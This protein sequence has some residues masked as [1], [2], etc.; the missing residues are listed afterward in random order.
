M[1]R[2]LSEGP[3]A[4]RATLATVE[5]LRASLR[6]CLA[7]ADRV[8]LVGT[9]ASLAVIATAAPLWRRRLAA[10]SRVTA[11]APDI[12]VRQS[13]EAV[14]GA[15]GI[16]WRRSDLA[17]LVSQSGA[18]PESVRAARDTRAA[19]A[20]VVAVTGHPEASLG[21]VADLIVPLA[22]GIETDASTKAALAS[23]AALLAVGEVIPADAAAAEAIACLLE[24]DA[25]EPVDADLI[26]RLADARHVWF[27]GSGASWGLATAG[28]LLW[29][30]KV[31]RPAGAATPSEFRHG[32]VE[33]VRPDDAVMLVDVDPPD[34]ARA[35]YLDRLRRELAA[36]AVPL[37]E[38]GDPGEGPEEPPRSSTDPLGWAGIRALGTLLRLQRIA[39]ATA[40][41]AG[42][43]RDGFAVLRRVVTP[44]TELVD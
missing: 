29:H 7:E 37:V 5:G 33:A 28:M 19:G 14:L 11:P 39:Y 20:R 21:L 1:A 4:V 40:V 10:A 27:I 44:A 35:A 32:L 9:G 18:S 2:E 23:L 3:S 26:R 42:T 36:I 17:V 41:L 8:V 16:G 15:D 12:V 25:T 13:A 24:V 43:Y 6:G 34:P 30:E 38:P 31:V 22:G